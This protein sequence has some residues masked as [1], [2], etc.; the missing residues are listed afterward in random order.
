MPK[1]PLLQRV[2]HEQILCIN[3]ERKRSSGGTNKWQI[4]GRAQSGK[5]Y[6][7][8]RESLRQCLH[9]KLFRDFKE[10]VGVSQKVPGPGTIGRKFVRIF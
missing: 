3:S 9:R 8:K 2:K 6:E 7:P 4:L 1:N 10:G 5:Q